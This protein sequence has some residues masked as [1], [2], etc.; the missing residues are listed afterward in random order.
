MKE[1]FQRGLKFVLNHECVFAKGHDGDFNFVVV[2]DVPGDSGGLTKFGI[3]QASNPD[4]NIRALDY[5]GAARIYQVGEWT[6]CQCDELPDGYDIAVF[7]IAVNNGM[8]R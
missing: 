5:D 6:K 7:D 8:K 3:D 2:E 1:N 4:V